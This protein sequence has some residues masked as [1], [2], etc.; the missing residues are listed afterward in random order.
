VGGATEVTITLGA[1]SGSGN[2]GAIGAVRLDWAPSAAATDLA[3]NTAST[4]VVTQP[5]AGVA[6]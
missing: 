2:T 5:T 1:K 4:A 3:G 6:F